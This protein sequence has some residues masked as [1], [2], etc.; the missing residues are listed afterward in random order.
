M[1]G[2]GVAK[3][4]DLGEDLGAG[5][6]DVLYDSDLENEIGVRESAND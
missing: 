5:E 4:E 1:L 3:T 2:Y 6:G